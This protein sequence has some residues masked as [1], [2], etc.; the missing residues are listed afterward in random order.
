[1]EP[2][3]KIC[4]LSECTL[5]AK[6]SGPHKRELFRLASP[7]PT[8][9]EHPP[10]EPQERKKNLTTTH[11]N[12]TTTMKTLKSEKIQEFFSPTG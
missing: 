11:I 4:A 9:K 10:I 12:I 6:I 7:L 3:K 8:S 2:T 1:M 5:F